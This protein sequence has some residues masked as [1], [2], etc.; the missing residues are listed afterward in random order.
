[1]LLQS[2]FYPWSKLMDFDR[3]CKLALK[4]LGE[5]KSQKAITPL[6]TC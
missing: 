6:I 3:V 5:K 4:E 2:N 1:M